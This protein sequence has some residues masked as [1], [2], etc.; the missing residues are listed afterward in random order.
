MLSPYLSDGLRHL[1]DSAGDGT[2]EKKGKRNETNKQ[3]NEESNC[4]YD[5][6]LGINGR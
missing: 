3:R 4:L 6:S 1:E 5:R 2:L